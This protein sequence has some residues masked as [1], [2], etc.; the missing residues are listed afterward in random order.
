MTRTVRFK[1]SSDLPAGMKLDDA[2]KLMADAIQTATKDS[3]PII[4]ET[5]AVS[6]IRTGKE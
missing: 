5:V 2:A 4:A 3:H 6:V 1:L